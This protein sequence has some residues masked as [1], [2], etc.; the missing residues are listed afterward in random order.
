[1]D[2]IILSKYPLKNTKLYK[3]YYLLTN[4]IIDKTEISIIAV[5]LFPPKSENHYKLLIEQMEYLKIIIKEKM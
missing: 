4:I 3:N 1:M 5:H 2:S